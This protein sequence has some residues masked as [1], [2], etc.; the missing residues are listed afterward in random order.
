MQSVGALSMNGS[1]IQ[2]W[3]DF[4]KES[5]GFARRASQIRS[6]RECVGVCVCRYPSACVPERAHVH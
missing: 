2:S 1:G 4:I 6:E 5:H 3:V